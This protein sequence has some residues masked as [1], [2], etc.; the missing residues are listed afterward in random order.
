MGIETTS[1]R[2]ALFGPSYMADA[3]GNNFQ[4]IKSAHFSHGTIENHEHVNAWEEN[5][6]GISAVGIATGGNIKQEALYGDTFTY[7]IR[8]YHHQY[9]D[10]LQLVDI[11]KIATHHRLYL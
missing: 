1:N 3:N 6:K 11:H 8:M 9:L 10:I 4:Q 2:A 7:L 5:L